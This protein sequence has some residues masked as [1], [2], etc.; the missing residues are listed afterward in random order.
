MANHYETLGVKRSGTQDEIRSAY[1]KLVLKHH[2]DRSSDPK[3]REIFLR[4]TQAYETLS[5]KTA[6]MEYD[7]LLNLEEQQRA[8]VRAKVN[9]AN[10]ATTRPQPQPRPK[11]V[12]PVAVELTKLVQLFSRG[13]M[14]EAESMARDLIKKAPKEAIPYGVLADILRSRGNLRE[15][16]KM[17]AFAAQFDPKNT[18]YQRRHEELIGAAQVTTSTVNIA[19]DREAKTAPLIVATIVSFL[20]GIYLVLS[21][22]TPLFPGIP[23]VSTL[24]LGVVVV[25]VVCGITIGTS[26]SIGGWIDQFYATATNAL[27][28]RSPTAS[29]GFVAA[30]NFWLAGLIYVFIGLSQQSFNYSTSRIVGAIA[31]LTLLL[32]ICAAPSYNVN[33]WQVLIWGGN[34]AYLASLLG[35][36][37]A[38][39]FRRVNLNV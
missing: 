2:P 28:R 21:R 5:D 29:L 10:Q 32:T 18:L 27:G 20:G 26:L 9:S 7:R 11:Q 6:R 3:S 25:C 16:S 12:E 22:E 14:I 33:A 1:R 15:A 17:Y 38:D 8:Q 24:T 31:A 39:A 34:I 37:V 36:M 23:L 4:V 35:W 19:R 30:I 13:R